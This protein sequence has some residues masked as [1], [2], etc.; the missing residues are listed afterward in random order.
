MN[1]KVPG[2]IWEISGCDEKE[3]DYYEGFPIKYTKDFFKING[4]EV[5]FYI[6]KKKF[7]FKSPLREYLNLIKQGYNDCN[8]NREYLKKRLSHYNM[9]L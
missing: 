7:S 6:N 5:M 3:L 2:G 1:T 8:L 4:K 9:K